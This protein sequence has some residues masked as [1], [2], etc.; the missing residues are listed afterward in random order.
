[1]INKPHKVLIAGTGRAGTTFLVRLLTEIG[2]DTGFDPATCYKHI[3]KSKGG[4]ELHWSRSHYIIKN[5]LICD[6]IYE[7]HKEYMIDMVYVPV[8]NLDEAAQSRI[9]WRGQDGGLWGTQES[10]KQ[11]DILAMK[12]GNL[13]AGLVDLRISHVLMT[14]PLLVNDPF[15][16]Y[17]MMDV[18]LHNV[19]Y[20][21]YAGIF[22]RIANE[23]KA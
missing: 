2:L 6:H 23:S 4:L 22:R 10:E 3:A 18:L 17:T 9:R 15:Y 16:T 11:R 19:R 21:E 14:F 5:P 7:I 8:R 12:L 20:D 13:I 1:M